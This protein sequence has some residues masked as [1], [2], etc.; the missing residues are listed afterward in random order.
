MH[1][2][3][4][5]FVSGAVKNGAV[6]AELLRKNAI[7]REEKKHTNLSSCVIDVIHLNASP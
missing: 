2:L 4:V 5:L 1:A 6:S 3:T 7:N